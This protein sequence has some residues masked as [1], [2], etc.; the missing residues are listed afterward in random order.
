MFFI[1]SEKVNIESKRRRLQHFIFPWEISMKGSFVSEV[2]A[3]QP[4]K[5]DSPQKCLLSSP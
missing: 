4:I 1:S 5:P 2:R 3:Q